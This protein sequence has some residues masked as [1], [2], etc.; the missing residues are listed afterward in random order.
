[1]A[2]L[3]DNMKT[4]MAAIV[5]KAYSFDVITFLLAELLSIH[6]VFYTSEATW[7]VKGAS[8]SALIN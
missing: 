4:N 3:H 6:Y 8:L 5:N 7:D 2:D 1:M